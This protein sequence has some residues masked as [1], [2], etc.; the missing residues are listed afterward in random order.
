MFHK[1]AQT[2]RLIREQEIE[3]ATELILNICANLKSNNT[4]LSSSI[5]PNILIQ[6]PTM[7]LEPKTVPKDLK[8]IQ[9]CPSQVWDCD[10]IGFD[11]NGSWLRLI[12][13][14]KFFTWKRIWKS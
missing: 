8:E 5:A 3:E 11:P 13:T 9:P 6:Q 1:I 4:S 7:N 12:Y 14:Y 10:E 2:Y